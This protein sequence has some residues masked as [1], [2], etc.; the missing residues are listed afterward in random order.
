[1]SRILHFKSAT[2]FVTIINH[3]M[4]DYR[5]SLQIFR[6]VILTWLLIM[7]CI[8]NQLLRFSLIYL[9]CVCAM[10]RSYL[11]HSVCCTNEQELYQWLAALNHAQVKMCILVSHAEHHFRMQGGLG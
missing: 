4:I 9:D 11:G 10:Y 2:Q 5:L 8:V 7:Y 1:M 6:D 3:D